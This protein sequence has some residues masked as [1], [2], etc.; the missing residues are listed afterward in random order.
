ML[1]SESDPFKILRQLESAL[2]EEDFAVDANMHPPFT[3]VRVD[4][5]ENEDSYIVK[6]DLPGYEPEDIS[7]EVE[8]SCLTIRTDTEQTAEQKSGSEYHIQERTATHKR[9]VRLPTEVVDSDEV[10]ASY[11][12][13]V[14]T[15]EIP[16][17]QD[18]QKIDIDVE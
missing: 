18:T 13:G 10:T 6:A 12:N 1:G 11:N 14:L 3:D 7:V 9:R 17:E 8:K 5:T 15:I 4:V 16:K 2:E